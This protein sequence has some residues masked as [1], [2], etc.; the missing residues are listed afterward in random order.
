MKKT[1]EASFRRETRA[2]SLVE[3]V[4]STTVLAMMFISLLSY[5]QLASEV[6]RRTDRDVTLTSEMGHVFDT[7]RFLTENA[8]DVDLAVGQSSNLPRIRINVA[9][10]TPSGLYYTGKV[11]IQVKFDP[12]DPNRLISTY[13]AFSAPGGSSITFIPGD[14]TSSSDPKEVSLQRYYGTISEHVA[15]FTVRRVASSS[16]EVF[17]RLENPEAGVVYDSDNATPSLTATSS[18]FL[19][20]C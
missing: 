19:P 7:F 8:S 3:V 9:T 20:G 4:V 13:T 2:F 1:F 6:W 18:F 12:A 15:T 17:V 10:G 14:D 16:L 11:R 5:V